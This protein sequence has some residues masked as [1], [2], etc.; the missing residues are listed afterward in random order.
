MDLAAALEQERRARMAAE[1]LLERKQAELAQANRELSRHARKLSVEIIEKREEADEVR[2]ENHRVRSDLVLAETKVTI[3]ERRLWTSL[4]TIEDGIALFDGQNA[5]VSANAAW[6]GPFD[7]LDAVA[8]GTTYADILTIALEE[9]IVDIGTEP[10]DRFRARMLARWGSDRIDPVTLRLYTGQYIRLLDRR[11]EDGDT[12]SL[13]L[14]ITGQVRS[15]ARLK[16]ARHR[17]EAASRAKSAFLANMSHE[18]RTPMNG[19]VGMA[20]ILAESP[21]DDEQKGFVETIR[22]SAEALLIIINDILDLSKID[23]RRMTLVPEPFD[24]DLAVHE[25]MQLVQPLAQNKALRLVVDYDM[26]L[27]TRFVGDPGRI[28]QILTN[29]I[30]NAVKF[31]AAGHVTLRVT[32]APSDNGDWRVHCAVEDTGI[33]IP[34]ELQRHIFG[35]F[36]QVEDSRNRRFE[37][38][39]LGLAITERLVRMM[40]G[41]IWVDSAPGKGSVFGFRITLPA[42]PDAVLETPPQPRHVVLVDVDPDRRTTVGNQLIALGMQVTGCADGVSAL[43]DLPD[44]AALL[45]VADG[46]PDLTATDIAQSLAEDGVALQ[47]I[48]LTEGPCTDGMPT[49]MLPLHRRDL[50]AALTD[51]TVRR[52]PTATARRRMRILAAEDN[53]TNQLVLG[54][55]LGRMNIDLRFADNGTQAV[56]LFSDWRPDLV[57]MDISMPGMDGKEATAR[58]RQIEEGTGRHTPIVALTAHA[59]DGDERAILAAGLDHYLSKPLRKQA[60]VARIQASRPDDCAPPDAD[61]PEPAAGPVLNFQ[62]YRKRPTAAE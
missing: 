41:D 37:G 40:G 24:L 57:F 33:G 7:G 46:L 45:L 38:T 19:V 62:T 48:R 10:P 56:A 18:L 15:E 34:A 3:A 11:G 58:I 59:L 17:A 14:D 50:V 25:V 16:D 31:T 26:F 4:A 5:M 9:G 52:P 55:I 51:A 60:I 20:D 21:L 53:R 61:E 23:A 8:P 29:L 28:R 13:A 36:N 43:A 54:K 6:L 32:G 1:H 49:L 27:P 44:D 35:E 22:S 2:S 30:G 42:D 47:V 39:G 12:V